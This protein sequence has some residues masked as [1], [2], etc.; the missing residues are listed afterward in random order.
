MREIRPEL[1]LGLTRDHS[2]VS[3]DRG[4][5]LLE[6]RLSRGFSSNTKHG[7]FEPLH[8]KGRLDR[9]QNEGDSAEDS[10]HT[11]DVQNEGRVG[12]KS[13]LK[14]WLHFAQQNQHNWGF[15]TACNKRPMKLSYTISID[16]SARLF[17][18]V[19]RRDF[20]K[21]I[22][23]NLTVCSKSTFWRQDVKE[24]GR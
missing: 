5:N 18:R 10:H 16:I 17:Q 9:D 21:R 8:D 6:V 12:F 3:T 23:S 20:I 19:W 7:L 11:L 15:I 13:P 14:D 24:R 4:F 1:D 22:Y 2:F